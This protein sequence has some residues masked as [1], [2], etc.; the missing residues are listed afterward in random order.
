MK[1]AQNALLVGLLVLSAVLGTLLVNSKPAEV[2]VGAQPG[3]DVDSPSQAI[4][5]V[6]RH[7]F[8]SGLNQAS[9]TICSFKT[10]AATTTLAFG[11]V[12]LTTGTTTTIALEM[13][14]ATTLNATTTRISHASVASAAQ[15][16]LTAFVASTTGAYGALSQ[17]HTA[18]EQDMV[19][20]PNT[21]LNVKYGG[22][23]GS[24]NVL[25]GSC[26]AE[27]IEN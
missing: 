12:K 5:G 16:T 20:A 26:K 3:P 8:S 9:T 22:T 21:Y 7:F 19:F 6:Q 17:A 4:N 1:N 18:D 13:G 10:P 2:T 24:A 23:A 11:S 27:F 15:V 14:K 25:V